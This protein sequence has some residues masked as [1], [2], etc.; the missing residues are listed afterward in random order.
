MWSQFAVSQR[1]G[2]VESRFLPLSVAFRVSKKRA[3]FRYAFLCPLTKVSLQGPRS[4]YLIQPEPGPAIGTGPAGKKQVEI[5][6]NSQANCSVAA[7]RL[8]IGLSRRGSPSERR[9]PGQLGRSC[10]TVQGVRGQGGRHA[11]HEM[12]VLSQGAMHRGDPAMTMGLETIPSEPHPY[13]PSACSTFA[14]T[15]A[16]TN[17]QGHRAWFM[18]ISMTGE[19]PTQS[20]TLSDRNAR[21]RNRGRDDIQIQLGIMKTELFGILPETTTSR[22]FRAC[23]Q[24]STCHL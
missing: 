8:V 12:A 17:R 19:S 13:T 21:Q 1:T 18:H 24:L 9:I 22:A 4:C 20:P 14:L 5:D 2:N 11:Q 7:V 3:P 10:L 6:V 23:I 15:R 16:V